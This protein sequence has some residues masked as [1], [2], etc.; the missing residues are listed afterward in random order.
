MSDAHER[1]L[2]MSAVFYALKRLEV[3]SWGPCV[4][5]SL[6]PSPSRGLDRIQPGASKMLAAFTGQLATYTLSV[7]NSSL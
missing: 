7:A 2:R 5:R 1:S 4:V 6:A 3:L